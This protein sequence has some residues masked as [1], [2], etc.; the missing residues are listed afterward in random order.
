LLNGYASPWAPGDR[1][2]ADY[3]GSAAARI[4]SRHPLRP[5]RARLQPGAFE[6]WGVEGMRAAQR[7]YPVWLVRGQRAPLRYRDLAW[8][9]G[10]ERAALA[11]YRL[12]EILNQA[13][14]S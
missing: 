6:A 11:G 8:S 7:A 13:L 9:I 3:I 5:L 1:T 4:E 14:G 12:A 2:E 10:E